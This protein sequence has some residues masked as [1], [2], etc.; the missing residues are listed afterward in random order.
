MKSL[1]GRRILVTRPAEQAEGL[2]RR[3]REAGGEAVCVPAIE[4]LPLADPAPFHALAARLAEFDLAIFI[5]RNAVR[6]TLDM[7]EGKAWPAG[8][9]VATVGQGSRA[10]LERRGFTN[11]I[12]PAAQPDSEALLALPELAGVR[13]C[14]VVIFRGEGGRE[15]LGQ[16]LAARGAKVEYTASYRRAVPD[17]ADMRRAWA[18]GV[19]AVTVSS[20]EGLANLL[21]MLGEEALRKLRGT[22]LFVPHERVAAEARS[23]GLERIVVADPA[24]AQVAAALVAHFSAAR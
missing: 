8:L 1:A 17:G 12:A 2:A 16:E 24:D 9:R 14:K 5:S 10:E 22:P 11:V 7:L 21:A 23:R 4:I 6:R 18:A 3:I 13:G 20:A 15:L 19:D